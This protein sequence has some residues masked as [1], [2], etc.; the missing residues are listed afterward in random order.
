[1]KRYAFLS[2]MLGLLGACDDE[3]V[4]GAPS[5]NA[6]TPAVQQPVQPGAPPAATAGTTPAGAEGEEETTT[7]LS[8]TD[9]EF[10]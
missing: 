1:M 3:V 2:I 5:N 8:Y 9:E 7:A 10:V 6:V 4:V